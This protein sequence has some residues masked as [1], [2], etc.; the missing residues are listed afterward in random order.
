MGLLQEEFV[1]YQLLSDTD[2][3]TDAARVGEDELLHGHHLGVRTCALLAHLNLSL[4]DY[5]E[6]L[7]LF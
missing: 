3:P 2:I 1:E 6:L 7:E 4:D 5:V